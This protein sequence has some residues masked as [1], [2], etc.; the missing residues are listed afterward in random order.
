M[1]KLLAKEGS[2][3]LFVEGREKILYYLGMLLMDFYPHLEKKFTE[4]E[5]QILYAIAQL[6]SKAFTQEE[7]EIA[8][9][10]H[11]QNKLSNKQIEASINILIDYRVIK[12]TAI[13]E[14]QLRERSK[15]SHGPHEACAP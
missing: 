9:Y 11:S 6:N 4:Q 5:A 3:A 2:I 12:R 14:Y 13:K 7:L 15:T 10:E 8:V 1:L